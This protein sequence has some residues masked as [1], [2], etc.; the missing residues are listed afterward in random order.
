MDEFLDIVWFK[1]MDI[2]QVVVH[3]MDIVLRH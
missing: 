1:I 3:G 2:A